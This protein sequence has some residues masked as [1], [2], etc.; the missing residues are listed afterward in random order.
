MN[1]NLVRLIPLYKIH[2][3]TI[4]FEKKKIKSISLPK[5]KFESINKRFSEN[6][7]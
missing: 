1:K 5:C 3:S 4:V 7:F 2:N 6:Q